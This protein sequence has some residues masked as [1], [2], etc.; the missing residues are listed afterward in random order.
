MIARTW[1]IGMF[2]LLSQVQN[3]ADATG[4]QTHLSKVEILKQPLK[5]GLASLPAD[6]PKPVL[7]FLDKARTPSCG[8]L[9]PPRG[10][11]MITPILETEPGEDFP[12]CL[13]VTDGA[14]F[15]YRGETGYVFS[16]R[17]RDTREESST[18]YF[19]VLRS[20]KGWQPL[21]K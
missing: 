3:A 8:L 9:Q 15:Q 18:N 19:F 4:G 7:Y 13:D 20:S 17:Q 1:I 12:Y 2:A 16:Y 14:L 6:A 11:S 5:P 21:D 10:A